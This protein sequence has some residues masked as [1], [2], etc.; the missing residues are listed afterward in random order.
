[1]RLLFNREL[2]SPLAPARECPSRSERLGPAAVAARSNR[3]DRGRAA[4]S[5]RARLR[6][7]RALADPRARVAQG[8]P[9]DR[10]APDEVHEGEAALLL[11]RV[12]AAAAAHLPPVRRAR[13]RFVTVGVVAGAPGDATPVA[14]RSGLRTRGRP[15]LRGHHGVRS[16][17]GRVRG[18]RA[19]LRGG[20]APERRR[21][22]RADH[23]RCSVGHGSR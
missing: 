21:S 6:A 9:E 4:R 16:R 13:A 19:Q 20:S 1:V 12:R 8:R 15:G 18:R 22:E 7:D 5:T 10:R 3:A 2:V 17:E 14:E 23:E 11:R